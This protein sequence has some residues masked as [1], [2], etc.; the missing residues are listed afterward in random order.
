MNKFEALANDMERLKNSPSG[1]EKSFAYL[2][3]KEGNYHYFGE[4]KVLIGGMQLVAKYLYGLNK[5]STNTID[6]TTLDSELTGLAPVSGDKLDS[7]IFGLL[8]STEGGDLSTTYSVEQK[9]KG[10]DITKILPHIQVDEADDTPSVYMSS[11]EM[12]E[13]KDGRVNY[14]VKKPT[15]ITL[16]NMTVDGE[17]LSDNPDVSLSRSIGVV[18][19]LVIEVAFDTQDFAGWFANNSDP[20]KRYFNSVAI[21]FGDKY[22]VTIDTDTYTEHRNV[23]CTNKYH[24]EPI[25]LGKYDTIQSFVIHR[26]SR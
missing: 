1:E 7:E 24:R 2:V 16:E 3:D 22:N 8:F 14:Y 26:Y 12:R 15:S 25:N 4:N 20:N 21:L 23:L 11:Y 19:R 6:I 10:F 18:S 9:D 17:V 5:P 13:V